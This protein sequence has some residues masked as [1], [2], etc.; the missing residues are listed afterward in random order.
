MASTSGFV[1]HVVYTVLH[2][3]SGAAAGSVLTSSCGR[4]SETLCT[5]EGGRLLAACRAVCQTLLCRSACSRWGMPKSFAWL[6]SVGCFCNSLNELLMTCKAA[7]SPVRS[8]HP[9]LGGLGNLVSDQSWT[10]AC[11]VALHDLADLSEP[12]LLHL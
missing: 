3:P 2:P 5:R 12:Q 10:P 7:C 11:A 9:K 8:T 6:P 1:G 4:P